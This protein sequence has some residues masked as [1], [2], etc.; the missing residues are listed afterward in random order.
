ML[1]ECSLVPELINLHNVTTT[2]LRVKRG[3]VRVANGEKACPEEYPQ[4]IRMR[5]SAVN[6]QPYH[7]LNG[8]IC[9][10]DLPWPF[11]SRTRSY[12]LNDVLQ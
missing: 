6:S 12:V 2:R 4:N 9:A 10:C 8:A 5:R 3:K 1:D 7:R 11:L